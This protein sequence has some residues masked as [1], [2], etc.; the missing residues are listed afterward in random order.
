MLIQEKKIWTPDNSCLLRYKA[1]CEDGTYIIGNDLRQQLDNL[2][3]DID[4]GEYLYNTDAANI[5]MDFMQNCVRLTKSPFYNKPMILMDWQKALIEATYSFKM[6]E[7]GFDRFQRILLEIARKNTKSETCSALALAE[8]IVGSPGADLVCSSN[9][10]AQADITYQAINTM[11]LLIDPNSKDTWKNQKGIR[12]KANNTHVFKLSDRTRN[13]EGRNI[14]YAIVDEVH[15]MKDNVIVKSIEQ[16]QSLKDNPKLFI[17]TT[18]GFVYEGFLDGE[19]K[20]ARKAIYKEDDTLASVRRLDWLYTQDSEIEIWT[21]KKSW[22]KSNP[23]L[24]IV[25]KWDYLEQQVELAKESK[26]DRI[27]VLSKDFNIKQNG[28]ESWLNEEDYIYS[29]TYDLEDF[30]GSFALGMVDLAETTDLCCAKVLM[31]KPGKRIKYIHTQYFIPASKLEPDRDDHKA[32]AKYKEWASAGHITICEDNEVD[33]AIVADWF[34]KLYKE[35][36][37]KML[38]CGYDQRFSRDW[39]ARM[40]E[41]GWTREGKELE[42]VLQNAETLNNALRLAESDLKA[43]LINYNENPVDRFCFKNACVKT[44]EKRQAL[45]VKANNE[46]KIDGAVTLI[47]VYEMYRRHKNEF[48]Q[49]VNKM[50]KQEDKNGMV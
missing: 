8:L 11:R 25:K 7:T 2:N 45:C 49:I 18:E 50:V 33:L 22:Q 35:N 9:D 21:N 30:R 29:A 19:L 1:L 46:N 20:K 24:G 28:A 23:T 16:S 4:S 12:N 31:M 14:D 40:T 27:F 39:I 48:T 13:K 37:I 36:D 5:R 17:I 47:G 44:N 34:Y 41:Y 32:G 38:Y 43:G 26:A 10:D 42:M 6:P 3:E 15:E